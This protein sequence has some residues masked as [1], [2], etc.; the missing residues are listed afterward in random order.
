MLKFWKSPLL[1]NSYYHQDDLAT[2]TARTSVDLL[3]YPVLSASLVRS[4]SIMVSF[5]MEISEIKDFLD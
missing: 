2:Y 4:R 5:L 1:Q 3:E